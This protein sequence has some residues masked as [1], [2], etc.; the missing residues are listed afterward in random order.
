MRHLEM[1]GALNPS[2]KGDPL[3]EKPLPEPEASSASNTT[4]KGWKPV[5]SDDTAGKSLL[6]RLDLS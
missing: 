1:I 3:P 4:A 5:K 2:E 6:Q